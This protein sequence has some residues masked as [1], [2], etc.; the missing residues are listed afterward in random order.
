MGKFYRCKHCDR[1]VLDR[2]S[3]DFFDRHGFPYCS[4]ECRDNYAEEVLCRTGCDTCIVCKRRFFKT[5]DEDLGYTDLGGYEYLGCANEEHSVCNGVILHKEDCVID[6]CECQ[7]C[8]SVFDQAV[9]EFRIVWGLELKDIHEFEVFKC[10][11][12]SVYFPQIPGFK[13]ILG[14]YVCQFTKRRLKT[15]KIQTCH[16]RL[17]IEYKKHQRRQEKKKKEKARRYAYE[18]SLYFSKTL[19]PVEIR[20]LIMEFTTQNVAPVFTSAGAGHA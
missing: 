13:G 20:T 6:T 5:N 2:W 17:M 15:G 11:I 3:L 19:P 4:R 1:E 7:S 18:I 10:D 9:G 14:K 12:C 16:D 8:E